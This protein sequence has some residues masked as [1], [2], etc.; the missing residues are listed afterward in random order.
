MK[1]PL[2]LVFVVLENSG[3]MH[4]KKP[5]SCKIDGEAVEFG[6]EESMVMIQV[7]WSAPE[8]V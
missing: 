7:P 6:Y 2:R 4:S 3:F 1:N 5:V 8:V